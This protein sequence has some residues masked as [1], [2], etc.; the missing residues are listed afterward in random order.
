MTI[1]INI[2]CGQSSTEGWENYDNSLGLRL[3]KVPILATIASVLGLLSQK[4]MEFINFARNSDIRWANATKHIP[5][6][7][8]SVEVLY[9]SHMLEHL[10]RDEAKEFFKE[11][12]R[13]LMSGGIIRLSVPDLRLRMDNYFH[14]EDADKFIE[15]TLLSRPKPKSLFE[16]IKYSIVGDRR[17]MWMYDGKSL[18][19]MLDSHGFENPQVMKPGTTNIPDPGSLDLNE[20]AEESLYVEAINP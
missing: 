2:G 10:D 5:H 19:K 1:R 9:S 20:R 7:D 14:D 12:R 3:S 4:Q 16:K 13:V 18:C 17:H 15:S 11:A 8:N 6:K